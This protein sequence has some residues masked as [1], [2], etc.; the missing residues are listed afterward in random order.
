MKASNS[1]RRL[2]DINVKLLERN[3]ELDALVDLRLQYSPQPGER[4]FDP[5]GDYSSQRYPL[6]LKA[7]GVP[8]LRRHARLKYLEVNVGYGTRNFD[9]GPGA[10][11]PPTRHAYVRASR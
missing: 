1:N 11:T 10:L 8:A 9:A 3:P 4:Q 2:R 6:V 7:S 5:F